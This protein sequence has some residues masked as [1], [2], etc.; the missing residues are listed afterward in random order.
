MKKYIVVFFIL[1]SNYAFPSLE[2]IQENKRICVSDE[3]LSLE[4]YF[5]SLNT[6]GVLALERGISSLYAEAENPLFASLLTEVGLIAVYYY[7]QSYKST[8]IKEN[9]KGSACIKFLE[10]MGKRG[11]L[12]LAAS[13]LFTLF[14]FANKNLMMPGSDMAHGKYLQ[15]LRA[16]LL[17]NADRLTHKYDCDTPQEDH[18]D[19]CQ[20]IAR[21]QKAIASK[22]ESRWQLPIL[23]INRVNTSEPQNSTCFDLIPYEE[24]LTEEEFMVSREKHKVRGEL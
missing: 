3:A 6:N 13:N 4:L 10:S 9:P 24:T 15:T 16:E 12:A 5:F 22:K 7:L 20:Y 17:E 19:V 2:N 14:Y 23:N 8:P 1:F 11:F 21:I 18:I